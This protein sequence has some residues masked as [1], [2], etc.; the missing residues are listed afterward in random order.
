M[1]YAGTV[2]CIE[3][4]K[5]TIVRPSL[6]LNFQS[7]KTKSKT[8]FLL[9]CPFFKEKV[10][11]V[12]VNIKAK[13]TETNLLDGTQIC[14]FNSKLDRDRKVFLLLRVCHCH[15]RTQQ[16]SLSKDLCHQQSEESINIVQINYM[17]WRL[18]G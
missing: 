18:R 13:I 2:D 3:N 8:H 5:S 17:S 9:D 4:A 1:H 16:Q 11:F 7:S 12:G 14:N 6:N 15:S 10:D